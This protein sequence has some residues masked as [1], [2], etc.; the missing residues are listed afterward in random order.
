MSVEGVDQ[1]S[2]K[3][4]YYLK[5]VVVEFDEICVWLCEYE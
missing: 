4:F 5:K 1:Q 3:F 2:E